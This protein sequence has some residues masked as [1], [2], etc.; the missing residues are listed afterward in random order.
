MEPT[1]QIQAQSFPFRAAE[2]GRPTRGP[3]ADAPIQ[4]PPDRVELSARFLRGDLIDR[5][6]DQI[7]AGTYDDERRIEAAADALMRAV[8][9]R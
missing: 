5:V 6:R 1:E 9:D 8:F 7:D 2:S 4:R 3:V